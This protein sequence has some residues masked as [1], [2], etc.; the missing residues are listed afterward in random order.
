MGSEELHRSRS[1][2]RQP[3]GE[4]LERR[5]RVVDVALPARGR[6]VEAAVAVLLL[7]EP[8]DRARGRGAPGA[9]QRKHR[10]RGQVD[11]AGDGAVALDLPLELGDEV[12]PGTGAGRRECEDRSLQRPRVA[13]RRQVPVEIADQGCA[14]RTACCGLTPAAASPSAAQPE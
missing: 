4:R 9:T 2:R 12:S 6:V 11:L 13:C 7:A 14:P 8:A 10:E 3:A 1:D 5:A